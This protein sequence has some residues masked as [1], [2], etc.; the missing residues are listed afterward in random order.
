MSFFSNLKVLDFTGE[1]GPYVGKLYAGLGA[2]VIHLEPM[3]GDPLRQI[4]PF[5]KNN[6]DPERSIPYLYY[7]SGKRGMAINLDEADGVEVFRELCNTADMLVESFSPGYLNDLGLSYYKLSNDN[8]KLV[9]VSVTPFGHNGPLS[10]REGSDLSVSALGGFLYLGGVDNNKPVRPPDNQ[11]YRMAESYAAVGSSIA[12]FD[13]VRTG[14]GQFVD[15]AS[16]EAAAMALET[17]PQNWDLEGDIRR[18]RGNE[19]GTGSIHPCKD[20]HVVV[21]AIMGANKHQWDAL[22]EWMKVEEV[23]DWQVFTDERWLSPDYRTSKEGYELF[24]RI[25]EAYSMCHDKLY[26]YDS[27]QANR[28][29][30]SPVSNGKDLL[31]NPQ[32]QSRDYW[33]QVKNEYLGEDITYPGAPYEFSELQWRFGRNAPRFGEHTAEILGSLGYSAAKI[34]ELAKRRVIH[35]C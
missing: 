18:G 15:V 11:T 23:E 8:P 24:C 2:D 3:T 31:E 6:P 33:Q 14:N 25:F 35:V 29:A 34:D 12:L 5:V 7:N 20:G 13:A 19:A 30:V 1:L 9:Q 10:N 21:V 28:V 4:G 16:V 17:A 27:A 32:L 26:I 22:V